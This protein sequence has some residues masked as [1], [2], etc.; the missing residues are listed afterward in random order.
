MTTKLEWQAANRELMAEERRRL[1]DPPTAEEV[2]AF[3]RGELGPEEN[4]R[5]REK[6]VAY[7]ELV[8][9]MTAEFPT[10]GAAPGDSDYLSDDEF[11]KHWASLKKRMPDAGGARV[12]QF[13]PAF[14]SIAAALAVVF[15]TLF[16][17]ARSELTKPRIPLDQQV[18]LPDDQRGAGAVGTVL[19]AQGE[20]FLLIVPM[21]NEPEFNNYRLEIVDVLANPPRRRWSS[22]P[23]PRR[24]ND[25]FPI[26]VSRKFLT[27]GKYQVVL[28]G[29]SGARQE[30]LSGYTLRVPPQ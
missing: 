14:G 12:L 11:A 9:T 18:L 2:L 5:I 22:E 24:A 16:W 4:A 21:I 13:W 7:P 15:G 25:S 29:V 23:M 1:G 27:P 17:Q 26:L 20:T 8:R 19:A 6:L 30:Q 28:Y 10:E 3:T